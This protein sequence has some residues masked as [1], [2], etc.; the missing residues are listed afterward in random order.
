VY[1]FGCLNFGD[2]SEIIPVWNAVGL[3]FLV[4]SIGESC[5][6]V[7]LIGV[8][9]MGFRKVFRFVDGFE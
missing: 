3:C 1:R 4:I 6:V 5:L 7:Y 8:V 2:A 9:L